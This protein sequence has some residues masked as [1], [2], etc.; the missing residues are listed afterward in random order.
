MH[1]VSYLIA[2]LNLRM[3]CLYRDQCY[4]VLEF[5][6]FSKILSNDFNRNNITGCLPSQGS[7]RKVGGFTLSFKKSGNLGKSQGIP[8]KSRNLFLRTANWRKSIKIS[9]KLEFCQVTEFRQVK[10]IHHYKMPWII[11]FI[12]NNALFKHLSF[13][14]PSQK[15]MLLASLKFRYISKISDFARISTKEKSF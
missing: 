1:Y 9:Y 12:F 15:N 8:V 7:Q 11:E 6:D 3:V 5:C 2:G 14:F 4:R 10:V 13:S